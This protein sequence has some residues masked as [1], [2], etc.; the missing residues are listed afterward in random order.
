LIALPIIDYL[1]NVHKLLFAERSVRYCGRQETE[2]VHKCD[3]YEQANE[4]LW[5]NNL[6]QNVTSRRQALAGLRARKEIVTP[7]RLRRQLRAA[8]LSMALG[9]TAKCKVSDMRKT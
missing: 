4:S 2:Q 9:N 1:E 8:Q 6:I 5:H 3:T 7:R